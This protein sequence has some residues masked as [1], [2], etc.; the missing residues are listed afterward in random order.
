M[1]MIIKMIMKAICIIAIDIGLLYDH[2]H[3]Y[4]SG[5][6]HVCHFHVHLAEM[7]VF[8]NKL[9]TYSIE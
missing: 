5:N 7:A 6:R 4:P 9:N 8:T 3:Y 2:Y 1:I